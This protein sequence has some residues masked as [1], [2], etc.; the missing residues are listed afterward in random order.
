MN[1]GDLVKII[2]HYGE[3]ERVVLG[4]IDGTRKQ[5]TLVPVGKLC[6][7]IR[8][9]SLDKRKVVILCDGHIGW[10]WSEE[11]REVKDVAGESCLQLSQVE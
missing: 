7:F 11:I 2:D 6:V 3:K 4:N 9:T 10:L 1:P 8:Y 5:Q